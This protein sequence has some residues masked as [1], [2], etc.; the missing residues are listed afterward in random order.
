[1]FQIEKLSEFEFGFELSILYSY[2]MRSAFVFGLKYGKKWYSD[3]I[4]SVS[5]LNPSLRTRA[6]APSR[7]PHP[8][9][10]RGRGT[11]SQ[12]APGHPRPRRRRGADW[13]GERRSGVP[14][15]GKKSW[16]QLQQINFF[17][18]IFLNIGDW[19]WKNLFQQ[20]DFPSP[21]SIYFFSIPNNFSPILNKKG[22]R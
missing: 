3:P 8:R 22:R 12:A 15:R 4:S 9:P 10:G 21:F 13:G 2:P 19:C 14:A 6:S 20:I 11:R 18:S 16:E 5:D 17:F 7:R 1:M